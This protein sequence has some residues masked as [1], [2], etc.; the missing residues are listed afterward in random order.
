MYLMKK[1]I[2]KNFDEV[3]DQIELPNE[4]NFVFLKKWHF[5]IFLTTL[6][7]RASGS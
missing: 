7:S 1:K 3:L 4:R 2:Q 6:M 5:E